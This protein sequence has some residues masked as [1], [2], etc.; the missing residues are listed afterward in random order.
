MSCKEVGKMT[1]EECKETLVSH[2]AWRRGDPDDNHESVMLHPKTIGEA[3]DAAV[4]LIDQRN[5]LLTAMEKAAT[6]IRR[7]DYTPAR[8]TLLV[9]IASAKGSAA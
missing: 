8:S 1:P 7:C 5:E 2:N 4:L 3:I 6:Q 9:A